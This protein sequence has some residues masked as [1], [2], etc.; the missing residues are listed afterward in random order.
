MDR[1]HILT[2]DG[3]VGMN[4]KRILFSALGVFLALA[5]AVTAIIIFHNEILTFLEEIKAKLPDTPAILRKKD[6]YTD[7]A[8]V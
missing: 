7:Y 3:G 8:D 5:A 1:Y 6:E 2:H 4:N